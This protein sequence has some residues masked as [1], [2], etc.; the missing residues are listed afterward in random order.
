MRYFLGFLISVGLIILLIFVLFR[1]GDS[2]PKVTVTQKSL[3]SY[4]TTDAEVQYIIDGP[5]DAEQLH[6]ESRISVTRTQVTYQR[7]GGYNRNV[8]IE[9]HYPNTQEG[10]TTLLRSLN[11]GGFTL[12]DTNKALRD[13]RGYCALGDRY[14]FV[15]NKDGENIQRFWSTSC[16]GVKTFN[17]NVN[18]ISSLFVA[19]VPDYDQLSE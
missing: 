10:F 6:R 7:L 11:Y 16:G 8:I 18:Y 5:V 2:K 13:D 19:Q 12:G 3:S 4:A 17:G 15:I 1:G 14:I 9:K